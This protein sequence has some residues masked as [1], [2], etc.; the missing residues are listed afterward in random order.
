MNRI[1]I[2]VATVIASHGTTAAAVAP[3][4]IGNVHTLA[5]R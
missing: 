3:A 5:V 4:H 2:L 1:L